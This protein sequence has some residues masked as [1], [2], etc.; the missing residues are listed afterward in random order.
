L[1][2]ELFCDILLW[3]DVLIGFAND[4]QRTNPF[5]LRSK[6]NMSHARYQITKLAPYH[7]LLV[8]FCPTKQHLIMP[9]PLH[10][11]IS[12]IINKKNFMMLVFVFRF[13]KKIL[14]LYNLD[15]RPVGASLELLFLEMMSDR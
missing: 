6:K 10:T 13:K 3:F 9:M 2:K 1:V 4:I 14:E 5:D 7:F 8:S 12:E 15:T 11:T